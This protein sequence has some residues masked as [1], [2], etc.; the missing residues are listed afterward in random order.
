MAETE[1]IFTI[2]PGSHRRG[3]RRVFRCH[4]YQLIDCRRDVI[5][6]LFYFKI[7]IFSEDLS[8]FI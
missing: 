6:L 3:G 7:F 5:K 2:I 1:N 8:Y 4:C